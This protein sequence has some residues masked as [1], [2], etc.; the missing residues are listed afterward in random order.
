MSEVLPPELIALFS[1]QDPVARDAAWG[2]FVSIHSRLL[3][4]AA[5]TLGKDYD[6]TMDRYSYA[7]EGLQEHDFRRLR[8]YQPDGRT[9]FTT[10]LLV[11]FRR[12][13]LDHHRQRYG[14]SPGAEP[15]QSTHS[16]R[17]L[18]RQ[19]A[20]GLVAQIDPD[21]VGEPDQRSPEAELARRHRAEQLGLAL[22][23]LPPADR[24]LLKFRFEDDLPAS[25]IARA[26][27]LP[28]PFHV[29]RRLNALLLSLRRSLRNA[30]VEGSEE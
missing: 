8:A 3:L 30:G 28:T 24:L 12:L 26:M 5:R 2:R 7:L 29:Y 6:G 18:R 22:S 1:A 27:G 20:D 25:Q 13:C 19:L 10:W 15:S 21:S 9:K 23:A 14:R 16:D 4:H 17:L 11:V